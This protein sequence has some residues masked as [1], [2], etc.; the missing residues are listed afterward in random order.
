MIGLFAYEFMNHVHINTWQKGSSVHP[1]VLLSIRLSVRQPFVCNPAIHPSI[2]SSVRPSSIRLSV[3]PQPCFFPNRCL[4]F[5]A[6]LLHI[7]SPSAMFS[8]YPQYIIPMQRLIVY[9]ECIFCNYSNSHHLLCVF[10]N[11]YRVRI[12]NLII[13]T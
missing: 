5:G 9:G 4:M 12:Y 13:A 7:N 8:E 1:L 10:I 11:P 6:Y 2:Y 3:H